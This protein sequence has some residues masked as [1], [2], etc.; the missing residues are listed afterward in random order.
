MHLLF[1]YDVF[2]VGGVETLVARMSQWLIEHQHSATLLIGKP[3]EAPH[4]LPRSV[5]LVSLGKT[6]LHYDISDNHKALSLLTLEKSLPVN[7]IYSLSRNTLSL[8]LY[9][10]SH[11]S[12]R[13]NV[14]AGVYNPWDHLKG[15]GH[16]LPFY[17]I[18][19]HLFYDTIPDE[20]KI[21]MSEQIRR[22]HENNTQIDL[23]KARVWPLPI[24]SMKDNVR[25][26]R[27]PVHGKIVSIG[28]LDR[29]KSYNIYMVDV[30]KELLNRGY[31]VTYDIY[32]EGPLRREIEEKIISNKMEPY[33]YLRGQMD[34]S[35]MQRILSDAFV[36]VGMGTSLIEAAMCGVPSLLAIAGAK[37]P[38]TYG[39][40]QDLPLGC[41]GEILDTAPDLSMSDLLANLFDASSAQYDLCTDDSRNAALRYD[42]D[43][44]MP[45]FLSYCKESNCCQPPFWLDYFTSMLFVKNRMMS[46]L[47]SK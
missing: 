30:V 35:D 1:V 36:F 2:I 41:C 37:A 32:G 12:S 46:L 31:K 3:A 38:F 11:L 19:H 18:R 44:L 9:L 8:A 29:M 23:Q 24:K 4:L 17:L 5:R 47:F 7:F 33:I 14:L 39:F 16:I 34:Y 10:S 25:A 13:P 43:T 20:N 15:S 27:T 45:L 40:L 28:R 6:N 22:N 21:F 26:S 42:A